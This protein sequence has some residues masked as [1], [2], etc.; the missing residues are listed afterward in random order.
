MAQR[1]APSNFGEWQ[2]VQLNESASLSPRLTCSAVKVCAGGVG[3]AGI[4]IFGGGNGCRPPSLKASNREGP[5]FEVGV[6]I[7]VEGDQSRNAPPQPTGTMT[8]CS[9]LSLKLTGTAFT[10]DPVCADHNFLPESA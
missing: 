7:M 4:S 6:T 2:S 9:P 1:P 10:A 5:Y 8:Y 3:T